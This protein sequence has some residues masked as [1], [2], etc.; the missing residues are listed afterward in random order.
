MSQKMAWSSVLVVALLV[1]VLICQVQSVFGLESL[2]HQKLAIGDGRRAWVVA[3]AVFPF[4]V[5]LGLC[6]GS[7]VLRGSGRGGILLGSC[8]VYAALI[9]HIVMEMSG[10]L[11]CIFPLLLPLGVLTRFLGLGADDYLPIHSTPAQDVVVPAL[12]ALGLAITV[13]GLAQ[14][15]VAAKRDVLATRGLYGTMRHPQLV[16]ITVWALGIA[17]WGSAVLDAL[18]WFT[19]AYVL[20]LLAWQ[21]EGSLERRFGIE[22]DTYRQS[23]PLMIPFVPKKGVLLGEGTDREMAILASVYV[24][25]VALILALFYFLSIR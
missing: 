4:V 7:A 16:G 23:T 10:A 11:Y 1:Y 25:G 14:I 12:I 5:A 8:V 22:Y 24:V 9:G 17:L 13:V 15:V 20:V 18:V 21:E 2:F 19:L 3:S 6:L